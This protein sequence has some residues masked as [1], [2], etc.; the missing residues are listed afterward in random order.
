[1]PLHSLGYLAAWRFGD[2]EAAFR[3]GQLGYEL[4]ERR[5]LRRF[6][7]TVCLN[8]STLV[9]PWARHVID[10]AARDPSNLRS[11]QQHWRTLTGR[12]RRGNI[13]LSNLLLAGD[14]LPE[15]EA[16]GRSRA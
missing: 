2:F 7:G 8:F 14:P 16:G 1:M 9:M 6:E 12:W 5:G 3:F 4:I 13:L 10:V 15:V 11:R